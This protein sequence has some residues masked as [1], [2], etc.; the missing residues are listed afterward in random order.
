MTEQTLASP[1]NSSTTSSAPDSSLRALLLARMDNSRLAPEALGLLRELLPEER[2]GNSGGRA[3]P[4]HL[5][6]ITAAGWRG[7]GPR[8]TL[9]LP[10]GPGLVVVAGPNGSG[11]SSF[12]E[13]AETALTARNFRW[14]GKRAGDWKQGWRNLHSPDV[15]PEVSAELSVGERS[16]TVTVR[17]TWFG[18]KVDEARTRVEGSDGSER[19]LDE[20]V[21]AGALELT[22]PFLPYSELGSMI[23]GSLSDLHDAFFKLLGLDLLAELDGRVKDAHSEYDGRVKRS[24]SLT[25]ELLGQLSALDDPRAR[26][27]AAALSGRTPDPARVRALLE[28]RSPADGDELTRLRERVSLAGP[29]LTAVT[30][31]VTRLREASAAA[32]Q[33]RFGSAEDAR[34]LAELLEAA[35]D[36]RWRSDSP[37]CP[38]CGSENR[39]DRTWAEH[40]RAEVERLRTEATGVEAA[41][42]ELA[43]TVRAVQDLVQPVPASLRREASP[44]ADLW[45]AWALCRDVTDAGELADRAERTA[46]ILHEACRQVR[47]EAGAHLAEHDEAWQPLAVRLTEWL[48]V[49]EVADTAH[50]RRLHAKKAREWLRPILDELRNERLRPYAERS[51]EIWQRLCEHSS[52][53]LGSVTLAGTPGRGSVKLGVSVDDMDAPAYSVMS[54]GELH[55]LALALFIPR[56]THE[57]SPFGFLV[58][59]DP[60]Q[61]MDP[62]KVEGLARVLDECARDRQVI[63]FTHDTRLQQAIAHLGIE[64]TI[65]RVTRQTDSV[66]GVEALTDPVEQALAEARAI[67]LD[68]NLPPDVA[69]HVLPA[70]C[71]VALEAA[72]LETARRRLRD[73]QGLGL[74]AVEKRV[75]CLERTKQYVSLALLGDERQ[76]AREAVEQLRPGGWRLIE[77]FNSGAHGPLP[78]VDDR[79]ALVARTKALATAIRRSLAV[80]TTSATGGTG[81]A[82]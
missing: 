49:A 58:I 35:L 36:H 2:A 13:A 21:D 4:V 56:A 18:A 17:R 23:N 40:A 50:T 20:V 19:K 52:V 22:R 68:P 62:E 34:R 33:A 51:Q 39:L 63:V 26:E 43:L 27:A 6:S 67:S 9:E 24:A 41:R 53:S 57:A 55:S 8:T 29:D 47:E 64:A 54:Q 10:P 44:L 3:G 61:S 46:K 72:C 25:A 7:I 28:G 11:K 15:T 80:G 76:S 78:T 65:L 82:R 45:R 81:S 16:E 5:R 31:A 14:E 32:E 12:A 48:S 71:R 38:V 59:D 66:V 42:R 73:E 69:N 79:K 30:R 70:M 74:R 75:E 77:A 1:D 37:D 60:V